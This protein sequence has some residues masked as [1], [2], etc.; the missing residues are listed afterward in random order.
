MKLYDLENHFY[1]ECFVDAVTRRTRPP[2][3]NKD[4]QIITWSEALEAPFGKLVALLLEVGGG[5]LELMD[6]LGIST[7]VLSC[8]PGVEDLGAGE[9]TEVA[10]KT[11]DALYELTKKYPGRYLGSAILPVKDVEASCRELERCVKD[12]GFVSWHTHSNYGE[13]CPSDERYLPLFEMSARLG[14]YVY[15]HPQLPQ[16]LRV[17]DLGFTVAGP[18]LGFTTDAM[19]ALTRL[20]VKGLF[21]RVPNLK[22]VLGHLGEA[23]PFLLDRMDN[24]F[25]F[26]PNPK[27]LNKQD[28][29]Y[30]FKNN[31]WVTTSGNMSKEAFAC[32]AAVMGIDR[33][34]FGS[35]HPYESAADMIRFVRELPL[36]E[37]DRQ[38]L[39]HKNAAALGIHIG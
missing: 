26:L 8:S 38:K 18:G 17:N 35:D 25:K 2:S 12:L 7:A 6:K 3:Y 14:A 4:T 39:Y 5:R 32:T 28:F 11:N 10:R 23:F 13:S 33:I 27:A 31:I 19:V 24:R 34:L 21:D 22:M 30:Y 9:S 16:G 15:L 37:T 29:S 1:D 20:V 36:G